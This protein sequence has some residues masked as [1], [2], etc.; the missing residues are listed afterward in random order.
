VEFISIARGIEAADAMLKA[1]QV[2][3]L[4]AHP[5]CSGKYI[6][7][8]GGDVAAV[9][10]AVDAGLQVGGK[11]AIDEF[12]IP[13]VHPSVI[14]A[15]QG[16][17]KIEKIDAVGI[18]ETFSVASLIEAADTAAKTARVH[19]IEIRA[20]VGLGGKSYATLTGEVAAV[21]S[22][23]EAGAAVAAAKGLLVSKVVI[24]APRDEVVGTIL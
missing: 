1:A 4:L 12:V 20:A 5:V 24:P 2:R 14:P 6:A 3:L 18:I 21:S 22:A 17:T 8:V 9:R 13:N 19:L 10:S 16:T 7:L 11:D 15:I 23:V